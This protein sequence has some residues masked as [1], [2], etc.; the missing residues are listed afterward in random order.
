VSLGRRWYTYQIIPLISYLP[1]R[2]GFAPS[3]A[4][5]IAY[6]EHRATGRAGENY[7]LSIVQTTTTI[8]TASTR[9][10]DSRTK[11]A[12]RAERPSPVTDLKFQPRFYTVY[13]T[14]LIF[15]WAKSPCR[16]TNFIVMTH[17]KTQDV[18]LRS[19]QLALLRRS[20]FS[21]YHKI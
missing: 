20:D 6:R 9:I 14:K 8:T 2:I 11:C 12:G 19:S 15:R 18:L 5:I 10:F 17:G 7:W 13:S 3:F 1:C 16:L 4:K 21:L